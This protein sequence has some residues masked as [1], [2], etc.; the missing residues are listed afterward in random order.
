M[1]V[2]PAWLLQPTVYWKW[3]KERFQRFNGTQQL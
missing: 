3:L 2:R 1:W